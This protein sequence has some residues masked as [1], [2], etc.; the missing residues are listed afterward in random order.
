[1]IFHTVKLL[2]LA[3]L[4]HPFAAGAQD[5]SP[6]AYWP[7]PVG[8]NVLTLGYSHMSGDVIPDRSLPLTGVDSSID[9]MILGYRH[10]LNLWDRTAN[11]TV[12]VPYVDGATVATLENGLNLERKYSGIGDLA[13]TLSVNILGAAAMNRQEFRQ[14]LG[15]FAHV[16]G[17]SVKLVAPTGKYDTERIINVGANRWAVKAELGYIVVLNPKWV[18][19]TS[20]GAWFFEDNDDF[21]DVIKE[22]KPIVTVQGHLVHR[23]RPGFWASLDVNYYQGGR[24]TIGGHRLDNSQQD[25]KVGATLVFPFA[26]GHAVKLGYSNGSINDS[27]ERF[28]V[29][30]VSYQRVF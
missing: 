2:F 10:T 30:H 24:S 16:L 21:L 27:D 15:S 23:F 4:L 7:A 9:S 11:I 14:H 13:A 29:F 17:A 6:R 28:N 25:S 18:L 1:M 22:Q 19:E 20:L 5:L 8:T 3:L 26:K 12:E